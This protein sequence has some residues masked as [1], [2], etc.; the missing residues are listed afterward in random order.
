MTD[1]TD[2]I[3][4]IT[5]LEDRLMK[6]R[7]IWLNKE[8]NETTANIVIN[9]LLLL[10]GEDPDKDIYLYIT[11]PGG[12]ITDG[13]GIYDA[14]KFISNDVVTV[15]I[16]MCASMGQFLL[17]SG[18]RG[19]RFL[20]PHARVLMHQPSGG[21]GGTETDARIEAQL[22]ESMRQEMASLTAEQTG[23][24]IDEILKD[25]EYDHWYNAQEALDYGFVDHI[26]HT[27]QELVDYVNGV[28]PVKTKR[29][30]SHRTV[31]K[32]EA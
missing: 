8:V 31:K 7:I 11:S 17:S 15:G 28:K 27:E 20:M 5:P 4:T 10:H 19:K 29:S 22:I 24:P 16:G 25:N 13:M 12:S 14:M 9:K 26:V 2:N 32:T 21:V 1:N 18:T 6:N 23:H 30:H 3:K